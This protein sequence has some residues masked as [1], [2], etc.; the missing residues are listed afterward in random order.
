MSDTSSTDSESGISVTIP[1]LSKASVLSSVE[2]VQ[3]KQENLLD[4]YFSPDPISYC[5]LSFSDVIWTPKK[6]KSIADSCIG[7]TKYD[8]LFQLIQEEESIIESYSSSTST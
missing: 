7:S 8:R 6:K 2:N 1:S 4:K 3:N 5:H